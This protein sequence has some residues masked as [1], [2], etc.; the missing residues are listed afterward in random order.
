MSVS[1]YPTQLFTSTVAIIDVVKTGVN[2]T[3]YNRTSVRVP[4]TQMALFITE[5]G[6]IK[7]ERDGATVADPTV[8]P[9]E[10]L[11]RKFRHVNTT[12]SLLIK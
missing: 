3:N 8:T 7:N 10:D 4:T 12:L 6:G 5:I 11:G 9:F 1:A 2:M